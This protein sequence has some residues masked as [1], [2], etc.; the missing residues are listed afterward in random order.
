MSK[1][2]YPIIETLFAS[3]GQMR[4]PVAFEWRLIRRNGKPFLLL[5]AVM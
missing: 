4:E 3:P 5:P 2:I 1:S